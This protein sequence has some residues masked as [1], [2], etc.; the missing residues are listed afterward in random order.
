MASLEEFPL[1]TR[2][3]PCQVHLPG[4]HARARVAESK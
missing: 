1:G 2:D 3:S 4:E